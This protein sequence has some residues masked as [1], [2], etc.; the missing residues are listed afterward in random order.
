MNMG[1][2]VFASYKQAKS[3]KL[4]FTLKICS[5]PKN[6]KSVFNIKHIDVYTKFYSVLKKNP[7]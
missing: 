5:P 7:V 4:W 6:N 2:A 3:T 1:S